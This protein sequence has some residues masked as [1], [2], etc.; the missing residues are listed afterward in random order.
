MNKNYKVLLV[1]KS[2]SFFC[3]KRKISINFNR[4]IESNDL[5]FINSFSIVENFLTETDECNLIKEVD[6]QLKKLRY[7]NDHF[8]EVFKLNVMFF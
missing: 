8:D 1:N 7:I 6:P 3:H 2:I 4:L 5:D